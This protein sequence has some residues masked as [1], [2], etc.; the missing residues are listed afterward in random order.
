[1]TLSPSHDVFLV[2]LVIP[3]LQFD[4]LLA[5][6]S[7]TDVITAFVLCSRTQPTEPPIIR[8]EVPRPPDYADD[9]LDRV[10]LRE[11]PQGWCPIILPILWDHADSN[12]PK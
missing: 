4:T 5:E 7:K 2:D 1:M 10:P 12:L 11:T 3:L 8:V 9:P 6:F